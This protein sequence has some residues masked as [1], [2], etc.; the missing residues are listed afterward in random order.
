[1]KGE[2]ATPRVRGGSGRRCRGSRRSPDLGYMARGEGIL[3]PPARAS[4]TT[5]FAV[6]AYLLGTAM[7]EFSSCPQERSCVRDTR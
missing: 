2:A 4:Y 1:M 7:Y 5:D 6:G 3:G